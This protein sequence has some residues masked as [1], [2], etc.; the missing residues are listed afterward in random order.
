MD[1]EKNYWP[2]SQRIILVAVKYFFKRWSGWPWGRLI[3]WAVILASNILALCRITNLAFSI[4]C[5]DFSSETWLRQER[6][7]E[8]YFSIV[9]ITVRIKR[10]L[11]LLSVRSLLWDSGDHACVWHLSLWLVGLDREGISRHH[12]IYELHVH[13]LS[14]LKIKK[15]KQT[16]KNT[17]LRQKIKKFF[18]VPPKYMQLR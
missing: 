10:F 4:F 16:G 3:F 18:D 15:K 9:W 11:L 2:S 14:P 17:C 12:G 13:Q 7:S 8:F 6:S 5:F 1:K